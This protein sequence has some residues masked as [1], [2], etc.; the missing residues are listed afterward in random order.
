MTGQKQDLEL[1]AEAR[2]GEMQSFKTL[3]ERYE[4]KVA[5]VAKRMLGDSPEATDI[6]QEVFIRFYQSLDQF[7]GDSALGTYLVRIA[8]N[9][10]LNELKRKKRHGVLFQPMELGI[11]AE[12]QNKGDDL[13]EAVQREISL[14]D[15][16][17]RLVVTLRMMEGYSTAETAELLKIPIGTVLSRLARA[18]KKLKIVLSKY[19]S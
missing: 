10:S 15:P 7:K 3:V 2:N 18:Q 5:G 17:F 4:G 14:L 9:L 12:Q 6:G 16:D 13:A 1:L 11:N 8:I 19:L